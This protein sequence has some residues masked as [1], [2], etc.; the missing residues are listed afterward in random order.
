M[1]STDRSLGGYPPRSNRTVLRGYDD[2]R[3]K[4]RNL[5]ER[6]F[7]CLKHFRRVAT[8][9]DKTARA[10]LSFVQLTASYLWLK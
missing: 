2:V 9:Y 1:D 6:M 8:R 5:V 4:A 3:Y 7:G 10:V